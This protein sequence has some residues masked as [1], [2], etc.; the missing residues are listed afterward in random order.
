MLIVV[1]G[2]GW[3]LAGELGR[4]A[5]MW[6]HGEVHVED[7]VFGISFFST[8]QSGET[9]GVRRVKWPLGEKCPPPSFPF[10][11]VVS[12]SS[13]KTKPGKQTLS[14][15]QH[16][17]WMHSLGGVGSSCHFDGLQI[18]NITLLWELPRP[19][20]SESSRSWRL[21]LTVNLPLLVGVGLWELLHQGQR[22]AGPSF[23]N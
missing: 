7:I 11:Q 4:E 17:G 23:R 21:S 9:S 1:P 6:G 8:V 2:G 20:T 16:T 22:E 3:Q 12:N 18:I 15:S 5:W 13:L 14:P 19:C 10:K